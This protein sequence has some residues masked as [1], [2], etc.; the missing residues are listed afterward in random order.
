MDIKTIAELG[1]GGGAVFIAIYL[2]TVWMPRREK[3]HRDE[4]LTMY[5][6]HRQDRLEDHNKFLDHLRKRDED[7]SRFMQE[8]TAQIEKIADEH[9]EDRKSHTSILAKLYERIARIETKAEI[10]PTDQNTGE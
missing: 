3:D 4:R 9:K 1:V 2:L 6:E 5:K 8:L 7:S 10:S